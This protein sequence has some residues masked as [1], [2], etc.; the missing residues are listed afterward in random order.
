M[1]R[2]PSLAAPQPPA[3]P[4]P[5]RATPTSQ[6]LLGL[7]QPPVPSALPARRR[8]PPHLWPR[9]LRWRLIVT[10][11]GL[12][13]CLLVVLAIVLDLV[14]GRV[15]YTTELSAVSV[16][17]R[18]SISSNQA[19]FNNEVGGQTRVQCNDALSFQQA[20]QDTVAAQLSASRTGVQS[21]YL[22][23]RFGRVLA[24]DTTSAVVGGPAPFISDALVTHAHDTGVATT[25]QTVGGQRVGI[26]VIPITYRSASLC[27]SRGFAH[28]FVEVV[29][30]FP[31]VDALLQSIHL[32]LSLVMVGVFA[33]G[34][35]I[36]G[37]L[38]ARAFRPLNAMTLT[39]RRISSG[40]LSQ[41][42]RL[43][44]T[45]DEVGQLAVTFDEMIERIE[46]AFA[47]QQLSEERM[48]QFIADASHEL[49]TPLTSI[50]GFI[51][52]LLR[53][54]KNDPQTTEEVLVAT[55]RET[56]RM[57]RLVTDLLT[58]AR[59]DAGRP[60]ELQPVDL[61]AL[62]GEAV[63]QA[64]ILAGTREVAMRS[65][66]QGRLMLV[67]DADRIKQVLLILLDN[68][69]K[70][71]RA[72]PEGWVR[73][74]VERSE[75]GALVS[76]ADNGEG[77]APE[78]LPHIFDRFYR[79]ERAARQRRLTGAQVAARPAEPPSVAPGEGHLLSAPTPTGSGLGLSIARA[80]VQAHGGTITVTSRRGAGATF[81]IAL[82]YGT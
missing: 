43:P 62:T 2:R 73:V 57:T 66:G 47:A 10:Y 78:D 74:Y 72:A 58:L 39:A 52:V 23:D 30:T 5:R 13:A 55:R 68:A 3:V 7:A 64:R 75:R 54:A 67:A 12:L 15:L 11:A 17:F 44:R 81:T 27:I 34:V 69:L 70:Y 9:T 46:T 76:I 31:H 50:R 49:R 41:R 63:D 45:G 71:G 1:A 80:I 56:E 51:D 53:G 61:I 65:D 14:M 79:A 48:R 35:L 36:G 28:G 42:T 82:P 19:R 40:D 59:L 32:V 37:P 20:F 38:I 60:L 8:G 6:P 33:L 18:A 16:D 29:T 22:L 24:P 26:V 4:D 25:M 77:I 21:V